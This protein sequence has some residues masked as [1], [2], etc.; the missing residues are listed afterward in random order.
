MLQLDFA[1]GYECEYQNEVQS[2]LWSRSSV[3]L[4]T[5]AEVFHG[6]TKAYLICSDSRNKD[7]E[8]ILVFVEHLYDHHLLKDENM[9]GIEEIIWTDGPSSEFQNKCIVHLLRRLSEKYSKSFT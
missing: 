3:T 7:K 2:A 8:T 4:F 6:Q 9:Q 1:M 5:A